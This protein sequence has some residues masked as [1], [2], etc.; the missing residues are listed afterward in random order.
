MSTLGAR[1]RTLRPGTK[2]N[3]LQ[4][5]WCPKFRF[6]LLRC[7]HLV[8][9]ATSNHRETWVKNMALMKSC[10]DKCPCPGKVP[11]YYLRRECPYPGTVLCAGTTKMLHS[12]WCPCPS[13]EPG[14]QVWTR[15]NMHTALAKQKN[16]IL[17]RV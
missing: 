12:H 7:C 2:R 5:P 6:N 9:T 16:I 1:A 3:V 15:P 4:R 11:Q 13:A 10:A 17:Y 14:H 8:T